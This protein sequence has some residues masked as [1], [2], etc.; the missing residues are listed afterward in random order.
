MAFAV[1]ELKMEEEDAEEGNGDYAEV[2][3]VVAALKFGVA[4]VAHDPEIG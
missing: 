3:E 4:D 2:V 1:A